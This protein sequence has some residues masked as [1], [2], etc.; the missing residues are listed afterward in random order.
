MQISAA[1]YLKAQ[2]LYDSGMVHTL[3]RLQSTQVTKDATVLSTA[4]CEWK[5]APRYEMC[6]VRTVSKS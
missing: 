6:G 3:N 4:D 2:D 1:S 5:S